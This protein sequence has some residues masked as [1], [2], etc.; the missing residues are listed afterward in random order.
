MAKAS[1]VHET[2]FSEDE[3]TDVISHGQLLSAIVGNISEM[4]GTVGV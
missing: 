1:T 2:P 4:D 3:E